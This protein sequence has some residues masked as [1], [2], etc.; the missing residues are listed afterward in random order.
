MA[1]NNCDSCS[2]RFNAYPEALPCKLS[3]NNRCFRSFPPTIETNSR[4]PAFPTCF[5][6]SESPIAIQPD[7]LCKFCSHKH[8]LYLI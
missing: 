2:H 1:R 4:V 3:N 7:P 6:H 8:A 5:P